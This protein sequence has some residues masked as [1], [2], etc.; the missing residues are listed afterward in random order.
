[1]LIE[2]AYALP[3]WL[4]PEVAAN[5]VWLRSGALHILPQPSARAPLLPPFPSLAQV[6]L[7]WSF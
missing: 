4:K 2:A 1:M 3:R 7:G 5:R 6:G